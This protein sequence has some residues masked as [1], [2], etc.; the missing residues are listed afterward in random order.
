MEEILTFPYFMGFAA[1]FQIKKCPIFSIIYN[2]N[3]YTFYLLLNI[4]AL[5]QKRFASKRENRYYIRNWYCI[6]LL[7]ENH[8]AAFYVELFLHE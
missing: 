3:T 5:T 4:S 2:K 1:L 6:Y 7:K 8:K